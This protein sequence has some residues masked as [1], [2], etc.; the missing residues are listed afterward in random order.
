MSIYYHL[1][2]KK[3][4]ATAIIKDLQ[5]MEAV[6]VMQENDSTI[7]LLQQI[8]VLDRLHELKKNPQQAISESEGFKRIRNLAK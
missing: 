6:E 1:K 5:K 8:E 3:K 4:Y 2:V 7:P